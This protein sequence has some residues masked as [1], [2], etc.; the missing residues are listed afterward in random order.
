MSIRP[1]NQ[2]EDRPRTGSGLRAPGR[3]TTAK[4]KRRKARIRAKVSAGKALTDREQRVFSRM[5]THGA[6]KR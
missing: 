3:R 2:K 1:A 4:K 6:P 5:V